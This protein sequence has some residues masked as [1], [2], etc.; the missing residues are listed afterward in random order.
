M[1]I[2][3]RE[4][5]TQVCVEFCVATGRLDVLFGEIYETFTRL[6]RCDVFLDLLEPYVLA[7]KLKRLAPSVSRG[8]SVKRDLVGFENCAKVGWRLSLRGAFVSFSRL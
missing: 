8:V 2:D 5:G 4:L 6:R 1:K 3:P 7:R